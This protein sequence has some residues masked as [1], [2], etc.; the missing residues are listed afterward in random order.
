MKVAITIF[1]SILLLVGVIGSM[2][3]KDDLLSIIVSALSIFLSIL[4]IWIPTT[5]EVCFKTEDWVCDGERSKLA[6]SYSRHKLAKIITCELFEENPLYGY[7]QVY[8]DIY[9]NRGNITLFV[10]KG[11]EFEGKVVIKG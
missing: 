3:I 2:I 4:S 7:Q 10:G 6:I 9:I 8:C 11:A 5:K 1:N